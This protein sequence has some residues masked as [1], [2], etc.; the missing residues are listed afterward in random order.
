MLDERALEHF[1]AGIGPDHPYA[2]IASINLASDLAV[3]GETEAAI[4]LG[5]D[6]LERGS[7]VL[8]ADHPPCSPPR[9]TSAST[10][11]PPVARTRRSGTR[12][13]REQ[14]PQGARRGTP[15]DQA[16]G[17]G[18]RADCDIDPMLM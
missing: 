1:R 5:R 11:T 16:A 13:R 15:G 12:N 14:V 9:S 8:G 6:A 10:S 2:I 7:R 17:R 18:A 4:E 3:L